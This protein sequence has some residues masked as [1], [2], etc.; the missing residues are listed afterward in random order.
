MSDPEQ[1]HPVFAST[2][3]LYALQ[4][5]WPFLEDLALCMLRSQ[6]DAREVSIYRSLGEIPRLRE[7]HLSLYCSRDLTWDEDHLSAVDYSDSSTT[8]G[9]EDEIASTLVDMTID[10]PLARSVFHTISAAK[11]MYATPLERLT[12]RVGALDLQEGFDFAYHLGELLRYIGRSWVC[13]GTLRDDRLHECM[14]EEYDLEEKLDREWMEE[15]GELADL[16]DV[17]FASAL[18]RAWPNISSDNWKSEW[19]S[20]PLQA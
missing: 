17:E 7:I 5:K 15:Q 18:Q 6:G 1:G 9:K 2:D 4:Q 10:E 20:F 14:V 13:T 8:P 12:L 3:L 16:V 19:H 11:T